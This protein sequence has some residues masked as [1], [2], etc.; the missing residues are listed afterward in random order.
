MPIRSERR[1][2]K[3]DLSIIFLSMVS[4][5]DCSLCY[6]RIALGSLP[7]P[8]TAPMDMGYLLWSLAS[9]TS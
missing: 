3:L 4:Y 6:N 7:D 1:L 9:K 5:L 8:K 2:R